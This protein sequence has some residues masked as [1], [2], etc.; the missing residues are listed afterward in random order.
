[1]RLLALPP[2]RFYEGT[3]AV[4]PH[5]GQPVRDAK[6]KVRQELI[7]S[8]DAYPYAEPEQQVCNGPRTPSSRA[9]VHAHLDLVFGF[10]R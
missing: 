10:R 1:M 9:V 6:A 5:A 7:E 8:G 4:G 3:M 2:C